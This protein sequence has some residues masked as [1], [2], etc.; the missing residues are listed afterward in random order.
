V[1]SAKPG[2]PSRIVRLV[3]SVPGTRKGST[4]WSPI[5]RSLLS[6]RML[7]GVAPSA[8]CHDPR[9][10]GGVTD[11]QIGSELQ[12]PA[13]KHRPWLID[14]VDDSPTIFRI[15]EGKQPLFDGAQHTQALCFIHR[16]VLFP[17]PQV[18]VQAVQTDRIRLCPGPID[19]REAVTAGGRRRRPPPDCPVAT[20]PRCEATR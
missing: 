13:M 18:H 2:W 10:T 11:D 14:G 8:V 15:P 6:S 17:A 19:V 16:T 12:I 4:R 9:L 7:S 20:N 5:Q 3:S 1:R